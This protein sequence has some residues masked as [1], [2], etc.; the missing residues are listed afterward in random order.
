[1]SQHHS[2]SLG[3]KWLSKTLRL[4]IYLRDGLQCGY[5]QA[6]LENG[7]EL[8]LDHIIP[9]S[10]LGSDD[11]KNLVTACKNC[12]SSRGDMPVT[13]FAEKIAGIGVE[14]DSVVARV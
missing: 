10:K 5:C 14:P 11:V 7:V 12:N 3:S 6:S 2:R 1:M 13:R 9:K 4:A 8:S